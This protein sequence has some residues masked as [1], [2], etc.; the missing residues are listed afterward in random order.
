MQNWEVG[1]SFL[2]FDFGISLAGCPS[3]WLHRQRDTGAPAP[4]FPHIIQ[5]NQLTTQDHLWIIT[6]TIRTW[7]RA[8]GASEYHSTQ[9][10]FS[11]ATSTLSLWLAV[12]GTL[13]MHLFL[14]SPHFSRIILQYQPLLSILFPQPKNHGSGPSLSM[15]SASALRC[16]ALQGRCFKIHVLS[17]ILSDT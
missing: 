14:S 2:D 9:P 6:K 15:F 1:S 13:H 12:F 10:S 11:T 8:N 16:L 4:K 17:P 7:L 5:Y 3:S